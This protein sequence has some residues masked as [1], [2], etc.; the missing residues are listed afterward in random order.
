M[1]FGRWVAMAVVVF[2]GLLILFGWIIKYPD[3]V[4]GFI[5]INSGAAPVK[6]VANTPGNIHLQAFQAQD[7]VAKGEYIAVIENSALT[8]DVQ[9]VAA[10][11]KNFHPTEKPFLNKQADFPEKVSLGDLNMKYYTFLSALKNQCDYEKENVFEKKKIS[12]NDDIRWKKEIEE[13]SEKLLEIVRQKQEISR[14]WLDKYASLNKDEIVTYEYELDKSKNEYLLSQQEEQSL[15]KEIASIRMQI[16]ENQNLLIQ[17]QVEQQEKE[18]Q[19]QLDLLASYHDLSDN[20]KVWE[21]KYVFKAPFHGRV[22]HLK[23]LTENQFVQ[24][25]EEIFGI[26]P[27][28]TNVFGQVLLPANGAGKVKLGSKVTVKLDNYPYMEY[29][30]VEGLVGS[31]SLLS[32]PQ[33]SEQNTIETYLLVVDLPEGLKTNYGEILDFQHEIGGT[34]DIIVKERRLIERLFDNLKYRTQ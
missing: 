17:L 11:I 3:T 16:T 12:L 26:V 4:T 20:I 24:A 28:E 13:E 31:I 27:K 19:L 23:F 2:A 10:L 5:K 6:L 7:E 1:T 34:A 33:R 15:L 22:E 21:Q 25:G 14:K 30:S 32:Q 9:T 8:E 18:R 29:G